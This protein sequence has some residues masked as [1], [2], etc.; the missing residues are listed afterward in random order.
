MIAVSDTNAIED[1][2]CS[3]QNVGC[4]SVTFSSVR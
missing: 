1:K 4:A 2:Y 3:F